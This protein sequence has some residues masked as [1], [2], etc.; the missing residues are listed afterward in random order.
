MSLTNLTPHPIRIYGWE[1]PDR[2]EPGEHEP[3][4]EVA[5]SGQVARLGEVDLQWAGLR[6][7]EAPVQM[8]EYG[9]LSGLPQNNADWDRNCD[10]YIVSLPVALAC[11]P[12]AGTYA[13]S[14]LLVPFREVR[15]VEGTVIGCRALA[16]PV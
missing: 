1:V 8:V 11:G 6:G 12:H 15:N 5:P 13:R 3:V 2:F 9:H 16:L 10:W 14:D 7:C 4:M